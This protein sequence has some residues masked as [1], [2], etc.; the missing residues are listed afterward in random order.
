MGCDIHLYIEYKNKKVAFD[1]YKDNWHSFGQRI[2]PGRN[3]A[4]FALMANVRNHYSDGKLPVL[5]EPR[6]I[7]DDAEYY[8]SGDDRI[9][10]SEE[11][12]D[13]EHSVTMERAKSWVESGSSKFINN[14]KGE[15]TWVTDPDN[16]S[17]SW[18][19]TSEF[20]TIINNYLEL[21]AG[22]HKERVAEHMTFVEQN[23]IKLES[24]AYAPPV[25]KY[26]PE[27]QVVLASMK[28]FEELGYDARIVFWFDN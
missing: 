14:Q 2:N 18:L 25:M 8:S 13:G 19:T 15:P 9:Y 26:E 4:M 6:G 20:E 11:K 21:E 17:H 22:W 28:R 1:G 27:Y 5:V 10:I 3:Y 7:P 23:N 16:H 12:Y 24:W